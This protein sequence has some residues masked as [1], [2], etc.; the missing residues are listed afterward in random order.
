MTLAG[1]VSAALS[2]IFFPFLLVGV[3][4][5]MLQESIVIVPVD[6]LT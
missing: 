3:V 6:A 1:A 2:F 4:F 5:L